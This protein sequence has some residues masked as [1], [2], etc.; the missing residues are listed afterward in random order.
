M[1]RHLH[2]TMEPVIVT[3]GKSKLF[4]LLFVERNIRR[5][6]THSCLKQRDRCSA[7]QKDSEYKIRGY[8]K[9]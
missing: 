7:P 1:N 3:Q 8:S 5:K 9:F 6:N 4:C 2:N